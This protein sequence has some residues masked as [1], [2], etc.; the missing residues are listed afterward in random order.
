MTN[1]QDQQVE[2]PLDAAEDDGSAQIQ[3]EDGGQ[4]ESPPD[5]PDA[6]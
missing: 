4:A 6:Q 5:K 1:P 2:E 3:P